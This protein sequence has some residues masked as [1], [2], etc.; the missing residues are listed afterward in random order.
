MKGRTIILDH[1][2]EV[3]AA[4]LMVDGRLHSKGRALELCTVRHQ[5]QL[6]T[7]IA[8]PILPARA[9]IH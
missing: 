4:A 6:Y 9:D 1:I 5:R 2:G 8:K 7:G 3:E